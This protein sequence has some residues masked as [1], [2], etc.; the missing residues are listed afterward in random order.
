MKFSMTWIATCYLWLLGIG[1][2][3]EGGGFLILNLLGNAAPALPPGV[4]STDSPHN[5]LHA[6]W[7][8][9]IL[10]VLVFRGDRAD[11]PARV[12]TIFGVFYL[13]LAVL[14]IVLDRPFGLVLGPGENVF[15]VFVGSLALC[16]GLA[17]LREQR[18][19]VALSR[20]A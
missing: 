3:L 19:P 4:N 9:C 11:I 14:G 8:L 18:V 7:G 6:V 5:A 1:L 15:H 17:A 13:T 16:L 10:G 20:P 2:L 12:S